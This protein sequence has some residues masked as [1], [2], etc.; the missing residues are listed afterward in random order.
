MPWPT[1]SGELLRAELTFLSVPWHPVLA[2]Q[3]E[4]QVSNPQQA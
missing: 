1:I 2:A 3:G 4:E